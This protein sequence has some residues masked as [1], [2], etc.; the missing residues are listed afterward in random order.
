MSGQQRIVPLETDEQQ[1]LF[2]WAAL[3]EGQYP[4]LRLLYA[5]PNGGA[6]HK[7]TA[8]RMKAEGVKSGVPD[9]CL[10]VAR[11]GCHALYIELKRIEG[12]KVSDEQKE[13]IDAL[14]AYGNGAT[15]CKGWTEAKDVIEW[16]LK[17]VE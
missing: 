5:I 4:E 10:P 2:Q 8:S 3:M 9:I 6:R 16:Y 15:V 17:G 7:A 1:A 12:G 13:W 11:R 14:Q